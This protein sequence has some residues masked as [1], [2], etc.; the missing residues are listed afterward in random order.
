MNKDK[1][2]NGIVKS[3]NGSGDPFIVYNCGDDWEN[4]ANYTANL[5]YPDDVIQGW[6]PTND[7]QKAYYDA[8]SS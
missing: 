4:F 5:T 1:V 3:V 2:L 6:I 7:V 8:H